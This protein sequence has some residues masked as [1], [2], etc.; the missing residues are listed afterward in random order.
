M[1]GA[2][3]G[4]LGEACGSTLAAGGK[5]VR[6]LLTLL[7]ARRA[8]PLS[9]AVI[10][11]AA[12]VELLHMATLVHDDVLD[13]AELRRG[14][15]DGGARSSASRRRCRRATSSSRGP[16]PSSPRRASGTAVDA[17]QRDAVGL[18]E[19]EVLQ[20]RRGVRRHARTGGLPAALRAQD[21]RPVRRLLPPRAP[22]SRGSTS[23]SRRRSRRTAAPRAGL[24]G[25][26]RHPRPQRR[27]GAHRQAARDRRA[28]RHGDPAADLRPRGAARAGAAPPRRRRPATTPASPR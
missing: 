24:P 28:R 14:A 27:R 17:A 10:R 3:A 19:G 18:S 12:A 25:L 15:T 4:P 6:P 16:S 21:G 26:R 20:R 11:A 23:A 5:R 8:A 9:D 2:Y 13:R 7:S 22:C 1:A